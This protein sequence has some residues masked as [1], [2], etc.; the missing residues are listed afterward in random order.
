MLGRIYAWFMG[1]AYIEVVHPVAP[2]DG[3][4]AVRTYDAV[5]ETEHDEEEG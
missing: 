5:E 3:H 4:H 2:E 1:M